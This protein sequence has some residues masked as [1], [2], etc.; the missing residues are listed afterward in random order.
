MAAQSHRTAG[1]IRVASI[2]ANHPYVRNIG[3]LPGATGGASS[4]ISRL[5][6]PPPDVPNPL[7]G[8][9][10]PPVMLDTD[11]VAGHHRE[12]DIA[13]LH[14][15]FDAAEPA[16]LR[17]WTAELRRHHRPLVVTVHDLVNPH[18]ADQ[19]QHDRQLDVLIPAADEVIT[20]TPGAAAV[21]RQRWGRRATVIPHPHVTPL[22]RLSSPV[23]PPRRSGADYVIGIH[24]KSLR[25]N[26]DPLAVLIALDAA[27]GEL[28]GAV[29]RVDLHPELLSRTDR[30]AVAFRE[31]L[32]HKD[33]DA[34]WRVSVHPMFT[35]DELWGYLAALDLYVLPYRFGTHS[36][37]LE[38]CVDLGTAVLVPDVGFYA[39]Q[40]GHP[41]Y[42]RA[43]DGA[44]DQQVFT[45]LLHRAH[46]DRAFAAPTRP[47]RIA[48][49]TEIAAAHH[50][51]YRSALDRGEP[52][53]PLTAG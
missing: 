39:E 17:R 49:R 51:I 20:L 9:W 43:S 32:A 37:W 23:A 53:G 24:A 2:P 34:R 46:D 4:A 25:A 29:V 50:S 31:W 27:I 35:D 14:F 40:H 21:I 28:P 41:R 19:H 52:D 44:I 12:F 13:H 1:A 26:T 8:Q 5:D 3:P 15:G 22:D 11:W 7:P 30:A 10:W 6:D 36:G 45:E 47:D 38:A 33:D 16:D 18:F 42:P 48:Q